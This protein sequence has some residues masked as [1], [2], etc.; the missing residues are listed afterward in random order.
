M[1]KPIEVTVNGKADLILMKPA[2]FEALMELLEEYEDMESVLA[3]EA[4]KTPD[5]WVD[6][7]EVLKDIDSGDY[8]SMPIDE[9]LNQ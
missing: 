6:A 9:L 1:P 7:S 3:Y 5:S 8:K 2:L 4:S